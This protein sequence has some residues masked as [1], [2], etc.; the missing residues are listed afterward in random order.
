M[1]IP[2]RRSNYDS[3]ATTVI[4]ISIMSLFKA[5]NNCHA[6]VITAPSLEDVG[7]LARK[8]IDKV[9]VIEK[10]IK[11][12]NL[13]L[14]LR[15]RSTVEGDIKEIANILTYALMEEE[16]QDQK[17]PM[18]FKFRIT[19][20]GVTSLLQSRIDAIEIGN[21]SLMEEYSKECPLEPLAEADQL[22]LLWNNEKFRTNIEKAALL[23]NEPHVWKEHNFVCAPQSFDWLFHKMIT[24]ENV[25]TGEVVGFGEI[26]MLTQPSEEGST[27]DISIRQDDKEE[28]SLLDIAAVPTIVNLVTSNE[29]RR[30]GVGS[31]IVNS[32]LKYVQK[33][34]LG[35]AMALYV[36]EDNIRAINLYERLG[37]KKQRKVKSTQQLY[38]TRQIS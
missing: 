3:V 27:M 13:E 30:C 26:A 15:I 10:K 33:T 21:K 25:V 23:S 6:L 19:A 17:T 16:E 35:E 1:I 7:R 4:M 9:G 8:R 14:D 32:A 38:M 12:Q 31:M 2:I 34:W 20:S 29:Y 18:N 22:R 28:C 24:A 5:L 11:Y 36:E 37:F